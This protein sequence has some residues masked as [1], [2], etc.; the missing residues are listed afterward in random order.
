MVDKL[1]S[2]ALPVYNAELYIGECLENLLAQTYRNI[3]IVLI[4]DCSTDRTAE[5]VAEYKDSRIRYFKNEQNLGIV[6]TLNKAYKLCRGEYIARMDADDLCSC[7]RL[8]KQVNLLEINPNV[9]MVAC[10]L[11]LFGARTGIVRYS[12]ES[13]IIQ[14]RLL[15]SLQMAHNAWL[16]RRELIEKYGLAYRDEYRYAE[17]WDFLVRASRVTKFS[18]VLE[19]LVKYRIFPQQSSQIHRQAQKRA[20]DQVAKDQLAH[21]GLELTDEEFAVYRQYFGSGEKLLSK[22]QM[23]MLINVLRKLQKA[24][25]TVGFYQTDAL[26]RVVGEEVFRLCYYNLINRRKSGLLWH[27]SAWHTA[28]KMGAA[29]RVKLILRSIITALFGVDGE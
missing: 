5:V 26:N 28:M 29:K 1:I 15:F 17:D 7:D 25:E 8:E 12:A 22:A 19:P 3:E 4:D 6:H 20:A 10:D 27:R 13:E 23:Q 16:F 11:E 21:I 14:C 18:N 2:V 24:N 9:G